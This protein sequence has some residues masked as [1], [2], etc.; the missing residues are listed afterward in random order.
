MAGAAVASVVPAAC[1][2]SAPTPAGTTAPGAVQTGP[3]AAPTV[4]K[5]KSG[6]KL[7]WAINQDPV[8]LVPFGSISTSNQWGKEFMYD[9]LV[10]WDKDLNVKPAL[11]ESWE[12]PDP[13]TWIWHLR[14]GVKFHSGDEVTADDVK[15]SIDLQANPPPPGVKIAQ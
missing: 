4:P 9:S 15:Y 13:K 8:N 5:P 3:T 10:E 2:P 11:A 14:K 6:G 1:A 7:T 12:T